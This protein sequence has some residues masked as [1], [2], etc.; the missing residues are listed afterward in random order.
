MKRGWWQ[1]DCVINERV[2]VGGE[3]SIYVGFADDQGMG[4][5][6]ENELD[7]NGQGK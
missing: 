7:I 4:A 5:E 3:L 1:K 2:N 6:T